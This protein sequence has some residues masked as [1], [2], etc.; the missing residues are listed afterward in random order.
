[1]ELNLDV[2]IYSQNVMEALNSKVH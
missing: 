1:M 2:T